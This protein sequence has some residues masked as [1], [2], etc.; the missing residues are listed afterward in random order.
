MRL[1][2]LSQAIVY[3]YAMHLFNESFNDFCTVA[4]KVTQDST[5]GLSTIESRLDDVVT[6][7][8]FSK[9]SFVTVFNRTHEIQSDNKIAMQNTL[10]NLIE[11][12]TIPD[13][14]LATFNKRLHDVKGIG[15]ELNE[16]VP[17]LKRILPNDNY[18]AHEIHA[19]LCSGV[20]ELYK[21]IQNTQQACQAKLDEMATELRQFQ[22]LIEQARTEL[23]GSNS[24]DTHKPSEDAQS[25]TF[26][27]IKKDMTQILQFVD[28]NN[29]HLHFIFKSNNML[30]SQL[31]FIEMSPKSELVDRLQGATT[32]LKHFL[33]RNQNPVS[34]DLN[35]SGEIDLF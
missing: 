8:L 4:S 33:S 32:L 9:T 20:D 24:L 23:S 25:L 6:L 15:N 30:T 34:I 18:P 1:F 27:Q 13:T 19:G 12:L 22:Q 26:E 10:S 29:Q 2:A 14:E 21:Q 16:V 3:L 31:L 35:K 28:I 7:L 11:L 17:D 5:V